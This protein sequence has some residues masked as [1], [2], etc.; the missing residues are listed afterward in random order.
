[1][2]QMMGSSSN[3]K[4]LLIIISIIIT[5][6]CD[7]PVHGAEGGEAAALLPEQRSAGAG[8]CLGASTNVL[9]RL[10]EHD[11]KLGYEEAAQRHCG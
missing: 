11:V 10:E 4:Q 6:R 3:S 2:T 1:M 7:V 9:V 5:W 8:T